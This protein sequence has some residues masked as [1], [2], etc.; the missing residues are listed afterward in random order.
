[1]SDPICQLCRSGIRGSDRIEF[2]DMLDDDG[3]VRQYMTH[4]QCV[5][6]YRERL[7]AVGLVARTN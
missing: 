7:E 3:Q 4:A 2:P 6:R 1:M 5:A